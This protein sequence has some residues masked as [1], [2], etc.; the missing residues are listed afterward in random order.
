MTIHRDRFKFMGV[1]D[2]I[3]YRCTRTDEQAAIRSAVCRYN[4]KY[5]GR[6]ITEAVG[7]GIEVKRVE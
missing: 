6:L 4:R 5:P 1:D 2:V 3:K 7:G